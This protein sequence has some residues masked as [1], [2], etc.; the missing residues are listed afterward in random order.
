MNKHGMDRTL[1]QS[2]SEAI[3]MPSN[4]RILSAASRAARAL[5][6]CE[7][8]EKQAEVLEKFVSGHDVFVVLPTG[9][10]KSLCYACLPG[11]FDL[12]FNKTEPS[13]VMVV[14]PL[15]AIMND[16]VNLCM[17]IVQI[18]LSQVKAWSNRGLSVAC[19]TS[20]TSKKTKHDV[21]SGV[22]LF[23]TPEL[24]I[25]KR[26][27]RELLRSEIYTSRIQACI[28]GEAHCIKNGMINSVATY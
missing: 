2:G 18:I 20:E 8:R 25:A 26:K 11:T 12:F 14:S 3:Q 23:F 10:G 28:V 27:W 1:L 15:V 19:I 17:I 24:L 5:H 16:Q 13:I 7:L 6:Y 21:I 9:Y 22:L 4:E